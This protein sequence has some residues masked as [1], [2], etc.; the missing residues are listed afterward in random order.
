MMDQVSSKYREAEAHN[1]NS[2]TLLGVEIER[3]KG[4]LKD[5]NNALS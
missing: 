3:L 5:K 4:I 1:E 2:L